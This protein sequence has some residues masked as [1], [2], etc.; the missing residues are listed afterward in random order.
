MWLR[1][2]YVYC[3]PQAS[4]SAV[5]ILISLGEPSAEIHIF[6]FLT[7]LITLKIYQF[8]EKPTSY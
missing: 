7:L 1:E 5:P 3:L 4:S 8:W 2:T 6:Y